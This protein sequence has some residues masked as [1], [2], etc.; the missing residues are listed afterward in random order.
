MEAIGSAK[1]LINPCVFQWHRLKGNS[2]HQVS[3]SC[4]KMSQGFACQMSSVILT[5]T[6]QTVL[7]TLECFLSIYNKYM[8][9]LSSEFD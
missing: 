5:D 3:T 2:T 4:Q 9:A 1:T 7:E 6:I 8:H